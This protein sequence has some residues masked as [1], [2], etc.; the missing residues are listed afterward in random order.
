MRVD[1]V[2]HRSSTLNYLVFGF[3][4]FL[5][6][7]LA[8]WLVTSTHLEEHMTLNSSNVMATEKI[9]IVSELIEIARKRTRLSHQM[10][11]SED[12]FEKDEISMKINSLAASFVE[13]RNRLESL[14]LTQKERE[15]LRSQLEIIP[16]V[17]AN[18]DRIAEL[19]IEDTHEAT[20]LARSIIIRDIVPV[21]S[22]V[23]DGLTTIMRLTEHKVYSDAR[24]IND[25]HQRNHRLRLLLL[26]FIISMAS[27]TLYIVGR[28][29]LITEKKLRLLSSTDG[30][31]G[32]LNRRVFQQQ[33]TRLLKSASRCSEP[34]TVM[35]I[36]V[37]H[38]K[39]YNDHYGHQKGDTCLKRIAAA[40]QSIGKRSGDITARFGGEEFIVFLPNADAE[41][42]YKLANELLE[43]VISL[44][45]ESA[46]SPV[47]PVVTVSVGYTSIIPSRSTSLDRIIH[48]ADT[49][50]YQA[51]NHGRNRAEKYNAIEG[52][53]TM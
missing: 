9:H 42:A 46:K 19:A 14:S 28:A 13:Y 52:D 35:L 11:L 31:T 20:E 48:A 2:Y 26:V 1:N 18:L 8:D 36:D 33:A 17:I 23:I 15:I 5:I 53:D 24:A 21:Q 39:L 3:I 51:K 38:F 47:I 37:D 34:V 43:L 25:S 45:I 4:I 50:L 41:A 27:I 32:L 10:L 29:V 30:L 7:L 16:D 44:D 6:L 22:T 40:I 12:V 49:A